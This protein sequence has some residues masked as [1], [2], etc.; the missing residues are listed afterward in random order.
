MVCYS[1][2]PS[3]VDDD[4][5]GF[6]FFFSS[7][8]SLH[9]I[10][11]SI[12]I[13]LLSYLDENNTDREVNHSGSFTHSIRCETQNRMFSLF[14][15]GSITLAKWKKTLGKRKEARILIRISPEGFRANILDMLGFVSAT[16]RD[17]DTNPFWK[18]FHRK[19]SDDCCFSRCR[20]F[21]FSSSSS[22]SSS[23]FFF[24]TNAPSH[25]S[26]PIDNTFFFYR[27]TT[28]SSLSLKKLEE[29]NSIF[30]FFFS[31]LF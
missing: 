10:V 25:S 4:N 19:F 16:N 22:S 6:V 18:F 23:S 27:S 30:F 13:D 11:R 3:F 29:W 21:F 17:W 1:S 2:S 5:T 24:T 12:R 15:L 20:Q 14:F 26:F 28:T 31:L 7:S 8:Y 9:H